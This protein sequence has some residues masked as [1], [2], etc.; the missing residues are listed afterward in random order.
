[1]STFGVL[2]GVNKFAYR[3]NSDPYETKLVVIVS[4]LL[5]LR[6]A[7]GLA[8]STGT[9]PTGPRYS[10]DDAALAEAG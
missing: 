5:V 4:R 8:Q 10:C 3:R 2:L 9:V 7:G 1:V 6:Y